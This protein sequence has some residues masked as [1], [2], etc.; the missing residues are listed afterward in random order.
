MNGMM[1]DGSGTGRCV[2]FLSKIQLF[3]IAVRSKKYMYENYK[4]MKH[5]GGEHPTKL[6]NAA[7]GLQVAG[8]VS[9]KHMQSIYKARTWN[10]RFRDV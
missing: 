2:F 9:A 7:C 8:Q 1:H 10:C 6:V 4:T 3:H 5:A